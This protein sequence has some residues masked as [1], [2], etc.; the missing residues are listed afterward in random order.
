MN[1]WVKYEKYK[2]IKSNFY[3]RIYDS[4]NKSNGEQ[5]IIKEYNKLY[6]DIKKFES[7]EK[8][9][10]LINSITLL[11]TIVEKDYIYII[12]EKGVF[13]LERYLN[14]RNQGFSPYNIKK[15]LIQLNN[16][17]KI[18]QE[19]VIYMHLEPSDIIIFLDDIDQFTFKLSI[20]DNCKNELM[21]NGEYSSSFYNKKVLSPEY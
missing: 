11:D 6:V 18:M 21:K 9:Y 8:F 10:K 14:Q 7:I 5:V 2:L 17:F 1:V 20:C 19:E 12:V 15:I 16:C 3:L 13:D 4:I